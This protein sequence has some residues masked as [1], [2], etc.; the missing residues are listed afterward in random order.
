MKKLIM[1]AVF[2]CIL[3]TASAHAGYIYNY[4]GNNYITAGVA[5]GTLPVPDPYT[6]SDSVSGSF[7]VATL[8]TDGV[9]NFFTPTE[10]SFFDGV[11]T[12]TDLNAS[13]SEFSVSI[14]GGNID[15]WKIVVSDTDFSASPVGGEAFDRSIHT[16]NLSGGAISD[17]GI[18]IACTVW[19]E[20]DACV[21]AGNE[22][23][24]YEQAGVNNNI[25]G[26]W[27]VSTSAVPEPATV[28]IFSIG[29]LGLIVGAKRKKA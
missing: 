18:D 14:T 13:A 22:S 8:L 9:H 6:T 28:W 23:G 5:G 21:L 15:F 7:V 12:I 16:S 17:I 24:F 10:F 26:S 4:T 20:N 27:S 25:P 19:L 11:N 3:F 1:G 29:L 2:S